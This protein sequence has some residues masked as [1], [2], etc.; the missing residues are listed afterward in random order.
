MSLETFNGMPA[1]QLGDIAWRKAKASGSDG[2]CVEIARL[3]DGFAVRNSRDPA[4]AALVFNRGEMEAFIAG[5][6][7]GEFDEM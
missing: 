2:N 5:A 1:G 4:G 7:N 3:H 6:K